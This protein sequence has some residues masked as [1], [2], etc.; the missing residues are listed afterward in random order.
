MLSGTLHEAEAREAGADSFLRKPQDI[1]SIVETVNR[2]V[3]EHEQERRRTDNRAVGDPLLLRR[4][5]PL[6]E[7][8]A[9][10]PRLRMPLHLKSAVKMRGY[11]PI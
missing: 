2:L 4:D 10:R 11:L 1:G 7:A 3:G 5:L 8:F 9:P 6:A